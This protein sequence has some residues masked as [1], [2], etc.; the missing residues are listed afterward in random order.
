MPKIDTDLNILLKNVPPPADAARLIADY[1]ARNITH[2][3]LYDVRDYSTDRAYYNAGIYHFQYMIEMT[4]DFVY[5][6]IIELDNGVEFN[7][8]GDIEFCF[9]SIFQKDLIRL[10]RY[11]DSYNIG[12]TYLREEIDHYNNNKNRLHIKRMAELLFHYSYFGSFGS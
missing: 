2:N 10:Q 9:K 1:L 7:C 5:P 12:C 6:N 3:V 11:C 4:G 8:I